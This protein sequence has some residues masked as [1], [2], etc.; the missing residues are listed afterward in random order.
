M[1]KSLLLSLS[2]FFVFAAHAQIWKKE[3]IMPTAD[4][5]DKILKNAA[6]KPIV[7]NVGPMENIKTAVFVGR[8]TSATFVD[9]MK[10]ELNMVPKT[11]TVV[12]YCG[13]CSFASCPNLKPAYDALIALGYKNV[14]VL[15]IPE[16]IKPDWVAKKYPM[17]E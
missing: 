9:Q 14:K 1:K 15:E 5:A 7:F 10:R 3:Q 12:V 11:R 4:L 17:E 16:G 2:L 13:C 8:A 6:D